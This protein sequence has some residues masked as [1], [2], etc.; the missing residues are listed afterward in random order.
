[1]K[2]IVSLII[3]IV[4]AVILAIVSFADES[5]PENSKL[6]VGE[7]DEYGNVVTVDNDDVRVVTS[8]T[9]EGTITIKYYKKTG[10]FEIIDVEGEATIIDDSVREKQGTGTK[11]PEKAVRSSVDS[12]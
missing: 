9:S 11:E 4:I 10:D 5:L 3:V 6:S 8:P 7:A 2:K 12:E 1:M